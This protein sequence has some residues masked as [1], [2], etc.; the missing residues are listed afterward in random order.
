MT[1]YHEPVEEMK[2]QDRDFARA[3]HSMKEELEAVDWYQQ[4]AATTSDESLKAILEHNRDEEI[5]HAC[6]ILEWLRRNMP[7][8]DDELKT[9]L[10]G[11]GAITELEEGEEGGDEDSGGKDSGSLNIGSLK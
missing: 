6:M 2:A 3:L 10:F 11:S 1:E 5:E 9:Y 4:R 7:A 8:W